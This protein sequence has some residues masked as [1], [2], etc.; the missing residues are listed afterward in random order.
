ML[1]LQKQS[2][3]LPFPTASTTVASR[4]CANKKLLEVLAAAD[5]TPAFINKI[6]HVHKPVVQTKR[7]NIRRKR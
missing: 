1:T 2:Q 4:Y 5:R 3:V 6:S 7:G